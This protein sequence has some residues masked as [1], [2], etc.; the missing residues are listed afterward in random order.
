MKRIFISGSMLIPMLVLACSVRKPDAGNYAHYQSF[1]RLT[2][3]KD[4][5]FML[6]DLPEDIFEICEI[7]R[8]QIVHHNLLPYYGITQDRREQMNRIWPQGKPIPGMSEMLAALKDAEPHNLYAKRAIEHRLIGACMLESTFLTG[9]LRYRGIPARIRA[10]YFEDIMGNRDHVVAFWENVSRARGIER[11]L[12][13]ENPQQWKEIMNAIT[14]SEQIE[15][16]KH[17]EHWICEYWDKDE[18]R[19]RLLDAN[20]TF[21]K[22]SSGLDVGFHLPTGHYQFAFEAWKE[23]RSKE[24]FNPDQYAE[25]RQDGRSHIRSQLLLDFYSLLNHDMAGFDDQSGAT[26]EFVKRKTYQDASIQELKELDVLADLLSRGPTP[27]EIVAFY[28]TCST[29]RLEAAESDPYSFIYK[30]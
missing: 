13:E 20:D 4:F 22:A 18:E 25:G 15:V 21:L 16:D 19:W 30:K 29:L 1:S 24:G 27:Q 10:G 26:M 2:D 3:P 8:Q 5:S 11:E 9:L 23:M 17:I 28:R 12:L 7:A 14:L 6:A